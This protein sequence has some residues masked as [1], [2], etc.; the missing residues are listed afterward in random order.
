MCKVGSV[1]FC[2]NFDVDRLASIIPGYRRL[3]VKCSSK[4]FSR[5]KYPV[6]TSE[7]LKR[8]STGARAPPRAVEEGSL[9]GV[10]SNYASQGIR[11]ERS[12]VRKSETLGV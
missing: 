5:I 6:F 12:V 8:A 7:V 11:L 4:V 10:S 9:G 3:N 2:V 1:F